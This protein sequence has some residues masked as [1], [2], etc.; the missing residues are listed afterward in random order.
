[1]ETL[2]RVLGAVTGSTVIAFI[3][4]VLGLTAVWLERKE[5]TTIWWVGCATAVI[6][7]VGIAFTIREELESQ[8]EIARLNKQLTES[9]TKVAELLEVNKRI[10]RKLESRAD[11]LTSESRQRIV[12]Q[13]KKL[14]TKNVYL[15]RADET[16]ESTE[17]SD[18]IESLLRDAGCV[19]RGG[20]QQNVSIVMPGG[21]SAGRVVVNPRTPEFIPAATIVSAA[22]TEAG[23]PDVVLD[24]TVSPILG[25][26]DVQITV[27]PK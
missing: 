12:E 10:A 24:P 11:I 23:I 9:Q 8:A 19:V 13:F 5:R 21:A 26:G 2:W 15:L 3:L 16:P 20:V 4:A 25:I 1:M 7:A 17:F 22:L 18:V 27:K 6:G 14:P